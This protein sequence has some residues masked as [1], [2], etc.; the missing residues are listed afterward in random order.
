[1]T[2]VAFAG[3]IP[4]D[5]RTHPVV[6]GETVVEISATLRLRAEAPGYTSQTLSPLFDHDELLRMVTRLEAEDL[7]NWATYERIEQLLRDVQLTFRLQ[8]V[9]GNGLKHPSRTKSQ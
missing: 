8:P 2:E 1:L 7:V 3:P 5:G 9:S 4:R 6:R